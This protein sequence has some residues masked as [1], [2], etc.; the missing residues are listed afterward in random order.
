MS[1]NF[2][3]QC[4]PIFNETLQYIPVTSSILK[5]PTAFSSFLQY[6]LASF[7]LLLCSL[8]SYSKLQC[9]RI[10]SSIHQ[11]NLIS[12]SFLK[13]TSV[14]SMK[15]QV[16]SSVP[17]N[18]PVSFSFFPVFSY[19]LQKTLIQPSIFPFPP[20]ITS[21][22]QYSL[23]SSKILQCLQVAPNILQFPPAC[24]SN[25]QYPPVSPSIL[26]ILMTYPESSSIVLRPLR[27]MTILSTVFPLERQNKKKKRKLLKSSYR[28]TDISFCS[29]ILNNE[30]KKSFYS[31]RFL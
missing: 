11:Y 23:V 9:L 21:V 30:K 10:S 28:M 24:S 17:E 25:V 13:S 5:H 20:V 18:S 14:P 27:H 29:F 22:V 3:I 16:F 7:N 4:P 1:T 6:P 2:G 26:F 19:T 15:P 31:C 12:F 8:E